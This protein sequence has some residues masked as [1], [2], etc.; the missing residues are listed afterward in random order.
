MRSSGFPERFFLL[1]FLFFAAE[2]SSPFRTPLIPQA[3]IFSLPSFSSF[4]EPVELVLLLSFVLTSVL[5]QQP[6]FPLRL[7]CFP[8]T[9][10]LLGGLLSLG[11]DPIGASTAA[12]CEAAGWTG[13]I[14]GVGTAGGGAA[15]EDCG[16]AACGV[17]L[18]KLVDGV[19][20]GEVEGRLGLL[21]IFLA[22]VS[23]GGGTCCRTGAGAGTGLG[24]CGAG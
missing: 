8:L 2:S 5:L 16:A 23:W 1:F 4:C 22:A 15:T 14:V 7:G 13:V 9:R 3:G 24:G 10:M 20:E 19:E 6:F 21:M 11:L 18:I 12:G 17:G